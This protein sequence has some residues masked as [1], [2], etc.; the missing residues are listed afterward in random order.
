M[1]LNKVMLIGNVGNDPTVR[2]LDK[3]N[4]NNL[5]KVASFPLAT[6][7]RFRNK[8]GEQIERTEWHNI[9]CYR[10]LANIIESYV[11][12]GTKLYIEG[13][14]HTRN[15][16]DPQTNQ[17]RYITEIQADNLELLSA[18]ADGGAQAGAGQ[19]YAAQ[20][21]VAGGQA[22]AGYAAQGAGQGYAGQAAAQPTPVQPA[23]PVV[24]EP[25]DDDL[26]F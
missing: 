1:S 20:G 6:S 9:V 24:P 14:I 16:V 3:N 15:Y 4:P 21:A 25:V 18:R 23:A 13:K 5:E 2:Y 26:P 8:A 11:K 12:K 10:G 17:T 7:E 19:G 22:G